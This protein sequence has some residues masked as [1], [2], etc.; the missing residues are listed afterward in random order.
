M[1]IENLRRWH[2]AVLG[3]VLG[4]GIAYALVAL[5]TDDLAVG[6]AT[7]TLSPAEFERHLHEPPVEGYAR[8]RDIVVYPAAEGLCRVKMNLFVNLPPDDPRRSALHLE[9]YDRRAF[10]YQPRVMNVKLPYAPPTEP[11]QTA[12]VGISLD[13]A[14][15]DVE[16]NHADSR[17]QRV[18]AQLKGWAGKDPAGRDPGEKSTIA[19]NLRRADYRLT[20]K[21]KAETANNAAGLSARFN[22]HPLPAFQ[23][24]RPGLLRTTMP[25]SDFVS[26]DTQ[27]LEFSRGDQ[28]IILRQIEL[29]DPNYTVL[30]YLAFAKARDP[31]IGYRYAWWMGRGAILTIGAVGGL[32]VIGGIWPTVL[33]LLTGAGFG[34]LPREKEVYDLSR[35]HG[36]SEGSP[37]VAATGLDA[38]AARELEVVTDAKIRELEAELAGRGKGDE[39]HKSVE[40]V[41]PLDAAAI[42]ESAKEKHAEDVE[43]AGEF[44]PVARGHG[45]DKK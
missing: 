4:L 24:I 33:S 32:V 34:R 21:L 10:E 11:G 2:W 6:A 15:V 28:S 30:D 38:D 22:D 16:V 5:G 31:R 20:V 25:A 44:Y 13:E 12:Q 14:G 27:T 36:N 18:P 19:L 39:M 41:R 40:A 26:G 9:R 29:L 43:F 3:V 37:K 42:E 23:S 8:V 17:M 35:F 1:G 45:H 7:A